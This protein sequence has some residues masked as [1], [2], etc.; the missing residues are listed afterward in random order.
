MLIRPHSGTLSGLVL[1]GTARHSTMA[2]Q[3][4]YMTTSTP[5]TEDGYCHNLR[6]LEATRTEVSPTPSVL[7]C[8]KLTMP[9]ANTTFMSSSSKILMIMGSWAPGQMRTMAPS[10]C[11]TKITVFSDRVPV[12]SNVRQCAKVDQQRWN[13]LTFR[14]SVGCCRLILMA[15]LHPQ[16]LLLSIFL[17]LIFQVT[18]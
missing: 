18:N 3:W 6:F 15:A 9:L 4:F 12:R 13:A 1:A 14:S 10:T 16:T 8:R 17:I 11:S 5:T 7:P 2:I